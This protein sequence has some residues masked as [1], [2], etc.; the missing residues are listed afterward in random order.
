MSEQW[1]L[2]E[3][4]QKLLPANERDEP[5]ISDLVVYKRQI[6][7]DV[8]LAQGAGDDGE[9]GI[10]LIL[11]VLGDELEDDDGLWMC[12]K[13]IVPA[14]GETLSQLAERIAK[15]LGIAPEERV[16]EDGEAS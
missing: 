8:S 15:G 13:C 9:E 12:S 5:D 16:W 7:L 14:T 6:T 11:T 10:S 4:I 3:G 2:A 1:T